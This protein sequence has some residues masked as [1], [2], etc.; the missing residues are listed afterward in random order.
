MIKVSV[1]IPIYNT[2]KYLDDTFGCLLEQTLPEI[3]ILVVNDGST[4]DSEAIIRQWQERDPRIT[5][6]N[7]PN[8]DNRQPAT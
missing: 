8:R 3:E 1:V 5:Y 4:D 7:Q 6:Y 2:G